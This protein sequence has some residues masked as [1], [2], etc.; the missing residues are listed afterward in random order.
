MLA[1]NEERERLGARRTAGEEGRIVNGD[2]DGDRDDGGNNLHEPPPWFLWLGP[3]LR[4]LIFALRRF[5]LHRSPSSRRTTFD[6]VAR[7][8]GRHD[9]LPP[10]P[11]SPISHLAGNGTAK[12]ASARSLA[13]TPSTNTASA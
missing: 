12:S 10:Q 9:G 2:Y 13:Y 11:C 5:L 7:L 8:E 3:D 6:L 1:R 4:R